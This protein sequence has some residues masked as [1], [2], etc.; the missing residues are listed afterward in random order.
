VKKW[1]SG[2][3]RR[4]TQDKEDQ[5]R[6]WLYIEA[7]SFTNGGFKQLCWLWREWFGFDAFDA[8]SLLWIWQMLLS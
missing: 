6:R 8:S 1:S 7:S 5:E 4:K 2:T 3:F